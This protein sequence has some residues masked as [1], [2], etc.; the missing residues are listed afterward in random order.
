MKLWGIAR[1]PSRVLHLNYVLNLLRAGN[2]ETRRTILSM[3]E[4]HPRNDSQQNRH[5]Q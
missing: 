2:G 5:T 1:L 4:D 3:E